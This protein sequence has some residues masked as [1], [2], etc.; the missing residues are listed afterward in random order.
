MK[1]CGICKEI[2]DLGDFGKNKSRRD[3]LQDTCKICR[4][5]YCVSWSKKNPEKIKKTTKTYYD[6]NRDK[7]GDKQKIDRNIDPKKYRI[8]GKT[9]RESNAEKERIRC[10]A[11]R[12]ANPDKINA[13]TAK[14]RTK[15]LQATPPWLTPE[16]YGQIREFYTLVKEL[17]WL[18]EEPLQVDHIV[19]LQGDN[20]CGLNVP[21]NLQIL[22]KS[23]NASKGNRLQKEDFYVVQSIISKSTN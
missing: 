13:L 18:S 21:W 2:K 19:P 6:A 11:Y 1:K 17:Q 7:I 4:R 20:V 15:K 16:Q 5:I 22:P 9:Y 12:D 23:M 8:R 10:K 14:R 3:G